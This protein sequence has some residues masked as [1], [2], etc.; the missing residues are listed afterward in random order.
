MAGRAVRAWD[1]RGNVFRNTYDPLGR[2]LESWLAGA[3]GKEKLIGLQVYGESLPNPELRNLR[4]AAGQA[5]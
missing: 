4:G 2:P 5:A 3:D 1:G